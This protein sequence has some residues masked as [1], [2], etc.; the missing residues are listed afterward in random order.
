V[1]TSDVCD[2]RRVVTNRQAPMPRVLD[3]Q[4]AG[5][6]TTDTDLSTVLIELTGMRR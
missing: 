2:D 3:A 5:A 4:Y 6:Q 1:T